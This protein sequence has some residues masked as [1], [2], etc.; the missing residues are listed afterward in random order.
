LQNRGIVYCAQTDNT[1]FTLLH[2]NHQK[3]ILRHSL[4]ETISVHVMALTRHISY[5]VIAIVS[6]LLALCR[7]RVHIPID[8]SDFKSVANISGNSH[9]T[10]TYKAIYQDI[11]SD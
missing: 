1:P 10:D 5:T 4:V 2:I 11:P 8:H 6:W 7:L 3:C 9:L